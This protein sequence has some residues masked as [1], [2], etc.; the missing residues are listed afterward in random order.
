MDK[1]VST[2]EAKATFSDCIGK[3]KPVLQYS[4]PGMANRL[5]RS[6]ARGIWNS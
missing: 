2:A 4:L 3:L 6:F 5:L 1:N